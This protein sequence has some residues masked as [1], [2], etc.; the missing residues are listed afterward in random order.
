MKK[1]KF[2]VVWVGRKTGVFKTW[3]ECKELVN[4]F[5][6]AKYKSFL[7]QSE[8]NIAL[9]SGYKLYWGVKNK[10]KKLNVDELIKKVGLPIENS[11][12]VDGACDTSTMKVEYQGVTTKGKKL[13]FHQGPFED[14]SNNIVEFLAIVHALSYCK[15]HNL[16][17]P[18]YSD[19]KI[20]IGW[21]KTVQ[22]NTS[23]EKN[24]ENENLFD[25]IDRAIKWLKENK[26]KNKILK[27]ETRAWG[28]N[29][30]D[31][32]RK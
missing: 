4:D 8:A 13:L 5:S 28:E 26:Y 6:G 20:A 1:S 14:G 21:V 12:S 23:R 7:T 24:K 2:Y 9:N 29:P 31:F 25:L 3:D 16:N 32:G 18:I 19:S 27:W 10:E 30:A 17:V 15:K 11:I 22:I